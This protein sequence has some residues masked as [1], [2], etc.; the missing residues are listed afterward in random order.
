MFICQLSLKCNATHPTHLGTDC[1]CNIQTLVPSYRIIFTAA[2]Q[3]EALTHSFLT[4]DFQSDTS[5]KHWIKYGKNVIEF[6]I[7]YKKNG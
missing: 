6:I 5:Q 4:N 7:Q 1:Q 3:F 2:A